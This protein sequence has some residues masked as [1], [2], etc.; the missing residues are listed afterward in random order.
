MY[1][2]HTRPQP[3]CVAHA[4]L[5]PQIVIEALKGALI[6]AILER[7]CL[8]RNQNWLEEHVDYLSL[9]RGPALP[10]PRAPLTPPSLLQQALMFKEAN[11]G[12]IAQI[13]TIFRHTKRL[14]E[15]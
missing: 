7:L 10:T 2:P 12:F 13:K 1:V 11:I 14:A 4:P 5:R 6:L 3:H 8:T 15:S 9:V